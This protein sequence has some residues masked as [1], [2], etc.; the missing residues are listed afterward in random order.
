MQSADH[1]T[2]LYARK[3]RGLNKTMLMRKVLRAEEVAR[4]YSVC[5]ARSQ[6]WVQP[7]VLQKK[8]L[9]ESLVYNRYLNECISL[10]IFAILGQSGLFPL[11]SIYWPQDASPAF[12]PHGPSAHV[13]FTE[14]LGKLPP[15]IGP[16][17]HPSRT[18]G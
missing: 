4:G 9:A 13:G 14:P 8:H 5:L 12:P 6:T 15:L 7:P 17:C 3:M 10:P 11:E 16:P 2:V 18:T 1:E